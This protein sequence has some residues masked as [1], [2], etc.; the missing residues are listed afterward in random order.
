[1]VEPL[2]CNWNIITDKHTALQEYI[3]NR[4]LIWKLWKFFHPRETRNCSI[5]F[6]WKFPL[7]SFPR[8]VLIEHF[9]S[10]LPTIHLLTC[11]YRDFSLLLRLL[12]TAWCWW[13]LPK[14]WIHSWHRVQA[15]GF[16]QENVFCSNCSTRFGLFNISLSSL[17]LFKGLICLLYFKL[18][19]KWVSEWT[20]GFAFY[21]LHCPV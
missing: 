13:A 16:W 6:P 11:N 9:S 7:N 19:P 2:Y 1:M 12:S 8:N 4:F 21:G 18:S 3:I 10:P 14:Q 5:F 15:T 17:V 20:F